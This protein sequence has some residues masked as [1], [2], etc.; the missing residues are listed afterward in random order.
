MY[1]IW[2]MVDP[3]N[4]LLQEDAPQVKF[5]CLVFTRIAMGEWL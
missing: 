1:M 2:T 5:M 4:H 3:V